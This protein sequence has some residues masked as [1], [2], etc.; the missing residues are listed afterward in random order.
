[1]KLKLP[2][3]KK[4]IKTPWGSVVKLYRDKYGIVHVSGRDW[5]DVAFGQG[6]VH[7]N[8][9]Q[10]QLFL[11]RI[12]IWGR[13]AEL[14]APEEELIEFDK[15]MRKLNF[16]KNLSKALE[17]LD[18]KAREMVESYTEGINRYM[19]KYGRVWEF[20]LL[21]YRPEP[22]KPEDTILLAKIF[23]F[24]GLADNQ[25][26]MEKFI[27]QLIQKGV[28]E[29]Y[30]KEL[31]PYIKGKIDY[32]LIK[33]VKLEPVIPENIRWKL[34]LPKFT[35]SNNWV[36]SGKRSTSGTPVLCNDPHLEVNRLPAIWEE[37][38]L[39]TEDN[40]A[41]G[42]T[43]PGA[44]GIIL[45]RTKYVAWGATFTFVDMIDYHIEHCR[46]GKYRRGNR[47]IPFRVREEVIRVKKRE[48]LVV[49]FYENENG[50][51]EGDPEKEGYYLT[52][53]FAGADESGAGEINSIL[54]VM[55]SRNVKEAMEAFR[56]M[57][58]S[59]FNFVIADREGNIGY[60]MTGKTFKRPP[61]IDGLVPAPAWLKKN[62]YEGYITAE[63]FPSLYNPEDGI[64]VTAN[65]DLNYLSDSVQPINL[66][67]SPYRSDRIKTLLLSKEK[68]SVED[69]KKIQYDLYSIQAEKI[70]EVIKPHLPDS[71]KGEIL[72]TWDYTYNPASVA[73][74]LFEGIYLEL[75]RKIFGANGFGEEVVD[76]M[77]NETALFA[78]YH[79]Y[80]DRIILNENSI[81]FRNK[82]RDEIVGE[83]V[84]D[85]LKK[86][87]A[88]PYGETREIFFRHLLFG[89]RL[90]PFLGFD[91]GPV[92]LPGGRATV[93]QGQIF[94]SGGRVTTFS[95][96]W[97]FITDMGKDEIYTNL[98]GGTTD[99]RFSLWYTNDIKN[100]LTG[101]YKVLKL[102]D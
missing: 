32:E 27:I 41:A 3:Q 56:K 84:T 57:R 16:K 38:V 71:V 73:P 44:P 14:L 31:F 85:A 91:Y 77:L 36:I 50:V 55:L 100:W 62:Q 95:P 23:G 102:G 1:M 49:K 33:K 15:L 40:Y 8:D 64:I 70:M 94:K 69:M 93:T 22:W 87:P 18:S 34:G 96:S 68:L 67:M 82:S 29:E 59:T 2:G 79:W 42:V 51:L 6:W 81:W 19:E 12:L 86:T 10:L 7:A 35:A 37:M 61:H 58:I 45:G 89:G 30:L 90:P 25:G 72:K 78:D 46:D 80:F 83:A 4:K 98:P 76:Y 20:K 88:I 74:T 48:E 28:G 75:L 66:A 26:N 17:E 9:R 101:I 24:I 63:D 53:H 5:K 60:Q 43:L 11:T 65:Q 39:R 92:Q 99:R 47:W 21:G 97:R 54:G 52:Y 13:S